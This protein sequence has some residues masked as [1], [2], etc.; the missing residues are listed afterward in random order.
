MFGESGYFSAKLLNP[1]NSAALLQIWLLI[2]VKPA[3]LHAVP[4]PLPTLQPFIH[5][6]PAL[7]A[8]LTQKN[9]TYSLHPDRPSDPYA[10]GYLPD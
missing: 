5:S 2:T 10:T 8:P 4:T 1:E 7:P 3:A 9:P 6:L